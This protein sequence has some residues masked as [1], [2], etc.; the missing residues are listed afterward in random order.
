LAFDQG[1]TVGAI[2]VVSI[3][4]RVGRANVGTDDVTCQAFMTW[5]E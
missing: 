5:L 3:P 2:A 4:E 1:P